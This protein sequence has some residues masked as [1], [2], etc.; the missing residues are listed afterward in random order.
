MET[1]FCSSSLSRTS[2]ESSLVPA[3]ENPSVAATLSVPLGAE[4]LSDNASALKAGAEG[5]FHGSTIEQV[6]S[7]LGGFISG[8]PLLSP[9]PSTKG[10][11]LNHSISDVTQQ[12]EGSVSTV[13]S[14]KGDPEPP[15]FSLESNNLREIFSFLSTTDIAQY[16]GA[17]EKA[18]NENKIELKKYLELS[19][20]IITS[21][22][23]Y[24]SFYFDNVTSKEISDI[25]R[26]NIVKNSI[27][28][29]KQIG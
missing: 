6:P 16:D 3:N 14:I 26:I 22:N 19:K 28:S 7:N 24:Q 17:I 21:A 4:S 8:S 15:I 13:E 10:A 9:P 25:K 11:I 27:K 12:Q 23:A 20:S 2:S 1:R 18:E 5:N 29:T